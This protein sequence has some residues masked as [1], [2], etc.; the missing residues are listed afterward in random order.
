MTAARIATVVAAGESEAPEFKS[1]TGARREAAQT[2]CAM[3]NQQGGQVLFG[4][5]PEGRVA[6]Q[7]VSGGSDSYCRFA[8]ARNRGCRSVRGGAISSGRS[9]TAELPAHCR[10]SLCSV[11]GSGGFDPT[12]DSS[13]SV[14]TPGS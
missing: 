3:L 12:P 14:G 1:T 10:A 13:D 5:T 9:R 8:T 7:Q 11:T 6:G 4:V 2:V